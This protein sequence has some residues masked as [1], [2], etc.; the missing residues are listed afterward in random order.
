L[1][2]MI[3]DIVLFRLK[4]VLLFVKEGGNFK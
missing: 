3:F 2:L 1:D 4:A